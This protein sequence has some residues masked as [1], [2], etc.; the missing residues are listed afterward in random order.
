MSNFRKDVTKLVSTL[1]YMYKSYIEEDQ[2]KLSIDLDF[3][4]YKKDDVHKIDQF[5]FEVNV[6]TYCDAEI[7]EITKIIK[8][9]ETKTDQ[10]LGTYNI[11]EDGKIVSQKQYPNIS[12][13]KYVFGALIPSLKFSAADEKLMFTIHFM[14]E[15]IELG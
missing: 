14:S 4:W 15:T 12:F 1:E 2:D 13:R 6:E 10:F 7:D 11:S 9:Y 8:T 3:S 5:I